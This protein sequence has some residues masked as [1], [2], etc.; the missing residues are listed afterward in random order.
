MTIAVDTPFFVFRRSENT[1]SFGL[2]QYW[3]FSADGEVYI[4]HGNHMRDHVKGDKVIGIG[5]YVNRIVVKGERRI[6]DT[7]RTPEDVEFPGYE[8]VQR[9]PNVPTDLIGD[10]FKEIGM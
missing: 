6:N 3:V 9:K 2:R 7:I 10:M 5:T 4:I 1:N 8:L